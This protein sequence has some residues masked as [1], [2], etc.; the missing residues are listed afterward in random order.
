MFTFLESDQMFLPKVL[1]HFFN[2]L[3]SIGDSWI[4]NPE[5]IAK[6]KYWSSSVGKNQ[7]DRLG[8]KK[9]IFY[10]N[11]KNVMKCKTP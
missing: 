5:W 2:A 3:K 6:S 7:S 10:I 9:I 1:D 8:N 11:V 4:D